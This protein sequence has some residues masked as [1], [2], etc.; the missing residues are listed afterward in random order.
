ML[1]HVK[2]NK[3]GS[4]WRSKVVR[5][6]GKAVEISLKQLRRKR[7]VEHLTKIIAELHARAKP[8]S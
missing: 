8:H 3:P 1:L 2:P 7:K 4:D 5:N 6:N